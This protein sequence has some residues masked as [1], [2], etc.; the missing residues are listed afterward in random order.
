MLT[1]LKDW[2]VLPDDCDQL[3]QVKYVVVVVV[4]VV[5]CE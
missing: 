2:Q 1:V 3:L 5:W 4:V